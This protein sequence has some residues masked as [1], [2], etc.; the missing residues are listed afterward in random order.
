MEF[1]EKIFKVKEFL[2]GFKFYKA[3]L[4]LRVLSDSQLFK[5][6]LKMKSFN[7]V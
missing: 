1:L 7:L 4:K 5:E 6:R 2:S 3:D